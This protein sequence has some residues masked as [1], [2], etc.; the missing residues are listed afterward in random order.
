MIR[1]DEAAS[2]LGCIGAVE[3][4]EGLRG[5]ERR[6]ISLRRNDRSIAKIASQSRF[7]VICRPSSNRIRD[8]YVHKETRYTLLSTLLQGHP[9]KFFLLHTYVSKPGPVSG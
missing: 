6:W 4:A 5:K 3:E 1:L 2:G 8:S 9:R 7:C